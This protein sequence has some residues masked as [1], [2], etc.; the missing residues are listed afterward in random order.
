[1]SLYP[2]QKKLIDE[3]YA[4]LKKPATQADGMAHIQ[5][6]L[7]IQWMLCANALEVIAEN[8]RAQATPV[9]LATGYFVEHNGDQ[10]Q[11][12]FPVHEADRSQLHTTIDDALT[13]MC[14]ELRIPIQKIAIKLIKKG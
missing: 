8:I 4:M 10:W 9:E 1:M 14:D 11:S 13:Y 5:I 7:M 2:E 12:V 3:I 6:Q